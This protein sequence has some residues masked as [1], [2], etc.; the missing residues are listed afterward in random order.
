MTDD[1]LSRETIA[2]ILALETPCEGMGGRAC[3]RC[4][5]PWWPWTKP[6]R[7]SHPIKKMTW[8]DEPKT[9]DRLE[10]L[11]RETEDGGLAI[12]SEPFHRI[13]RLLVEEAPRGAIGLVLLA[14]VINERIFAPVFGPGSAGAWWCSNPKEPAALQIGGCSHI[15]FMCGPGELAADIVCN[16]ESKP[17]NLYPWYRRAWARVCRRIRMAWEDPR[18]QKKMREYL[19]QKRRGTP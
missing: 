14:V 2:D 12:G 11:A 8:L 7:W 6:H 15:A 16:G 19:Q 10:Q 1:E 4:H 18:F 5:H 9:P 3:H 17:I 13:G